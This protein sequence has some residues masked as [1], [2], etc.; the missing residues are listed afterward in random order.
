MSA[1]GTWNLTMQTPMGERRSTLT[2]ATSGGSLTGTQ[3]AEGNTT[4]I[5]DGSVSGNDVSWKVAITNPMP[6]T[7]TFSGSVSGNTLNGTADTGMFGSFPFEG[8][9]A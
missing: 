5:T 4:D 7:L 8:T 3:E 6:L 9:R 2:L 1:D